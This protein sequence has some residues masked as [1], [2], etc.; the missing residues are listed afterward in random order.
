MG[1]TIKLDSKNESIQVYHVTL[2][3]ETEQFSHFPKLISAN[4]ATANHSLAPGSFGLSNL[5]ADWKSGA[6]V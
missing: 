4:S 1:P 3:T 5:P 2:K 6:M